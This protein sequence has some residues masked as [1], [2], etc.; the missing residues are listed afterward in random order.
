MGDEE[1]W[2]EKKNKIE[3]KN[4]FQVIFRNETEGEQKKPPKNKG[5]KE[6][7]VWFLEIASLAL[8]LLF[9][10]VSGG[11][12]PLEHP[13]WTGTYSSAPGYFRDMCSHH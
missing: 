12:L 11:N 10:P 13:S 2:R 7:C 6:E 3:K 1:G 8:I 4:N 5:R 9:Y